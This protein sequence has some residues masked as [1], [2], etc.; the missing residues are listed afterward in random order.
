MAPEPGKTGL[1]LEYFASEG[2]ALWS[3]PDSELVEMGLA[4]LAKLELVDMDTVRTAYVVRS[5][6]AYPLYDPGYRERVETIASFLASA[7]NVHPC[8][9]GGLHRYNNMDHSMLTG[10]LAARNVLGG[11]N[12]MWSVNLE[13]EYIEDKAERKSG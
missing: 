11:G 8:G 2:D 9:R 1:G 4:E 10:M 12:D 13:A 5:P 3:A 6:C 7:P